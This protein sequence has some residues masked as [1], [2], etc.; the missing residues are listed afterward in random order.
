MSGSSA[1]ARSNAAAI[2]AAL[3]SPSASVALSVS[4]RVKYSPSF[5]HTRS[6]STITSIS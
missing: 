4:G 2:D 5:T 1:S 3:N 6:S